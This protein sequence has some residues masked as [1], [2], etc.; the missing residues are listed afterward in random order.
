MGLRLKQVPALQGALWVRRGLRAFLQSPLGFSTQLMAFFFATMLLSL[1]L[2]FV[3]S[4]L[5][6]MALPLLSLA[7]MAGTASTLKG[8]MPH[9]GQLIEPL[10]TPGP[11]RATL[12]KL[13]GL[14]GAL[15]LLVLV[16]AQQVMGDA[17]QQ[18]QTVYTQDA[19]PEQVQA[20]TGDPRLV[21]G[22]GLQ[23]LLMSL[24]SVPFWHAPAL[25]HWAGQGLGQALFSSTVAVWRCRGAFVVYAAMWLGLLITAGTA[26]TLIAALFGATRLLGVAVLPLALMGMTA[27][28]ASLYFTFDDSFGLDEP[29]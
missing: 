18:L 26:A 10:R 29:A 8:G 14:Y 25:V 20:A 3:G 13:C 21:Q 22:L 24:L 16:L 7:A 6:L 11:R 28:Y 9:P 19:T 1:L 27:F 12:L 15:S 5:S 23:L 17:L 2:P 4:L